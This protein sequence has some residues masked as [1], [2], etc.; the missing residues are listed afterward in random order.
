MY[1]IPR[2]VGKYQTRG[3]EICAAMIAAQCVE[4]MTNTHRAHQFGS[5]RWNGLPFAHGFDDRLELV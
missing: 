5:W 1:Q 2:E 3:N 4:T